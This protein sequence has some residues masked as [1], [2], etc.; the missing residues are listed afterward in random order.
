MKKPIFSILLSVV[1]GISG[2]K[3]SFLEL[4]L[5]STAVTEEALATKTGVQSLLVGTYH[6]LT[7]MS[8]SS[9]WWTATGTN[10]IWGDI[11]AGDAYR[12]GTGGSND[13]PEGVG[14]ETFQTQPTYTYV[15]NKFKAVYDGVARSNA[16]LKAVGKAT[17]M[18]AAEKT[19]KQAEARFLRGHFHFEAKKMWNKVPYIDENVTDFKVSNQT[20]IWPMIEA[21]LQFAYM[22]LP[23]KQSLKGVPNKWAAACYLAKAYMFQQKYALAKTLLD[24][25][26]ANGK[27]S[28]GMKYALNA[29]FQDNF[30]GTKEN[31]AEAVFQIQFSANDKSNGNNSNIGDVASAPPIYPITGWYVTWKQ[32]S[33]NLVNAFKTDAKGLPMPDTY[34]QLN[35]KND[36]GVESSAAFVPYDGNVDPRLDWTVGRRGIPF[37]DYPY[38]YPDPHPGKD[39]VSNQTFGGPFNSVK[40]IYKYTQYGVYSDYY[41]QGYLNTSAVNYNLIRFADVLLWAAECEVE[42]G[43]LDKARE[44]VNQIRNRAKAGC[45]VELND[46]PAANYMIDLYTAAWTDKDAAR[47]AVRFERRLELAMEGHRFFD[48]VRWGIASETINAYLETEKT[49]ISRLSGIQFTKGK[50]EYYPLPQQE[51]DLSAQGGQP[52]LIQNPGY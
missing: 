8:L 25:I 24:N 19:A 22:N 40:G 28:Q 17:D 47:K 32:P 4:P 5:Q 26:I 23:E 29:C 9:R 37:L 35:M 41:A 44:Y 42:V 45:M 21:D 46:K 2:C 52:L 13:E 30:D 16:V 48:L 1:A 31:S 18:T 50:N 49:R 3:E 6:D 20:D 51:I 34:N 11:T 43:S 33:F 36:M 39:W 7:G 10:W 12:G 27:N 14:I 15:L 38:G